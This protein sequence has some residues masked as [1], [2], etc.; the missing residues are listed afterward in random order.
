MHEWTAYTEPY[1]SDPRGHGFQARGEVPVYDEEGAITGT[2]L[3][4]EQV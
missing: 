2:K 3:A 4:T 1:I